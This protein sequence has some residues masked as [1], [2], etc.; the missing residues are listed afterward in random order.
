MKS[1]LSSLGLGLLAATLCQ[2]Q[3]SGGLG[4]VVPHAPRPDVVTGPS[5]LDSQERAL[6]EAHEE[7]LEDTSRLIKLSREL[8][9]ELANNDRTVLSMATVKKM[10][11]I[12]RLIK[13]IRARV[14][15]R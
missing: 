8:K 11:D 12:E 4:P 3:Q 14:G 2:P 9:W 10:E 6:Q 1:L 15:R 5:T 13:R 7:N